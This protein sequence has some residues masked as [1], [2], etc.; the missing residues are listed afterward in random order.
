MLWRKYSVK[1]HGTVYF[2]K[3]SSGFSTTP[4]KHF[5][6]S[7]DPNPLQQHYSCK[8]GCKLH[9]VAAG[10]RIKNVQKDVSIYM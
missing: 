7:T 5:N 6:K 4:D 10:R 8:T 3:H 9:D 2:K 1:K